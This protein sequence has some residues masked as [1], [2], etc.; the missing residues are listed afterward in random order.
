MSRIY[1]H[2]HYPS[3]ITMD[4]VNQIVDIIETYLCDYKLGFHLVY[5]R[6]NLIRMDIRKLN[7]KSVIATY[8]FRYSTMTLF[9][10]KVLQGAVSLED[11]IKENERRGYTYV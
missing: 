11:M 7:S 2:G 8:S 4:N 3:D 6:R 1:K 9:K 5:Q 10:R